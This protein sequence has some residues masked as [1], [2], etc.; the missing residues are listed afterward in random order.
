MTENFNYSHLTKPGRGK[1]GYV[2]EPSPGVEHRL[3]E[4]GEMQVLSPGCMM[5]YYKNEEA[6]KETL[7]EGGWLRTGDKGVIDPD[8][9][10]K[11]TGRTKEIFKTSKGKY[12]APAPIENQY[13]THPRVELACVGG[14]GQ[15]ASHVVALLGEDAVKDA[16]TVEGKAAIEKELEAHVGKVNAGL[17]DHER[18]QFVA[19]VNDEWLPEN[20]FVTPTNKIKRA[21]IEE[22]YSPML[23]EWYASKSKVIWYKW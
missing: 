21:K 11:I 4:D 16:A 10:F 12:V 22:A 23:E 14:R 20:G 3:G 13:I 8:G 6:T 18:V 9:R 19:I 1:V 5:G 2:G 7:M 15:P 17:D